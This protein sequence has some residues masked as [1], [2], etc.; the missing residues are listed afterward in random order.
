MLML[1]FLGTA[2][3]HLLLES[4][5]RYL[6]HVLPI[7]AVLAA[8]GVAEQYGVVKNRKLVVVAEKM[9]EAIDE[10][11]AAERLEFEAVHSEIPEMFDIVEAIKAGHVTVSVSEAY[12]KEK[13]DDNAEEDRDRNDG[14]SV[15][16]ELVGGL[17]Q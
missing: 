15:K 13:P 16:K 11:M 1:I 6:Y 7:F 10:K 5:N 2:T 3:A 17:R 8:V 9:T 4:Q 12:L 14:A